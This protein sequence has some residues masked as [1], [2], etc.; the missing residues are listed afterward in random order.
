MKR[1]CDLKLLLIESDFKKQFL[2]ENKTD[3]I[4]Y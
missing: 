2:F 4:V 3:F 1:I